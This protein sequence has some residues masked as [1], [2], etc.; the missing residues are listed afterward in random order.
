MH[1]SDGQTSITIATDATILTIAGSDPSG[2]AGLQADLKTFQQLGC[3]GMSVV[4][5]L[6]VQNTQG[7]G[8]VEVLPTELIDQQLEAVLSDIPPRVVK[9][10]ALG[11]AEVIRTVSEQL[12][13]RRLP[14]VVD[15]VLISK[16]GHRL[17]DDE[18]LD[19]YREQL[20]PLANV[21][22]PNRFEAEA[23][24]ERELNSLQDMAD[25]AAA[26]RSLGPQFVVLKAGEFDGQFHHMVAGDAD[27]VTG[28][29][30]D[31]LEQDDTHGAGCVFSAALASW[32]CLHLSGD[33]EP[34][35]VTQAVRFASAAV[36]HA[37]DFAPGLGNGLGPVETR[38][39]R[40]DA[41]AE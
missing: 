40:A 39:I 22:T 6:T 30:L 28:L 19:A 2:G 26:L 41:A 38:V 27:Q 16:H 31:A 13:A 20:M 23:L 32:L 12:Q 8:R 33:L 36:H 5:L 14:L 21:F 18:C 34:A 29:S 17:A 4:T 24:L 9:T 25:A 7:V 1:D 11:S 3:Y 37:I 35:L 15:P 10:G